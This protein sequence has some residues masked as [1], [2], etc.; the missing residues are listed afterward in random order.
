MKTGHSQST[1]QAED[2]TL[3]DVKEF[4]S[5]VALCLC[6]LVGDPAAAA[7]RQCGSGGIGELGARPVQGCYEM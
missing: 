7:E 1:E 3:N 6:L 2:I 4:L 5:N